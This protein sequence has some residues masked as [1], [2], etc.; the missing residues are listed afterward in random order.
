MEEKMNWYAKIGLL[1]LIT[2]SAGYLETKNLIE[3]K[4]KLPWFVYL[5]CLEGNGKG[6]SFEQ[7]ISCHNLAVDVYHEQGGH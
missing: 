2:L 7:L 1:V 6:H 5:A 3:Y 4:A